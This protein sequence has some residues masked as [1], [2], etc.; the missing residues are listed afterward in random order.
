MSG[1]ANLLKIILLGFLAAVY[2]LSALSRRY[3]HV[4]W[5]RAFRLEVKVTEEQR[6][7]RRRRAERIAGIELILVG[8]CA[9]IAYLIVTLMTWGDPS[10]IGLTV[11]SL[12]GVVLI[13]LGVF[14]IVRNRSGDRP[15]D[16]RWTERPATTGAAVVVFDV[17]H[18]ILLIRENYGHRRWGL[19]GGASEH[20]ETFEE[21]A[22][23]EALEETGISVAVG[24]R[25]GT[26]VIAGN[27]PHEVMVYLGSIRSGTPGVPSSGEIADVGWFAL[28]AIPEPTTN[29]LPS[30][31]VDL[32]QQTFGERRTVENRYP[33]PV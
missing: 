6:A 33:D 20:G 18:R 9:P 15:R 19:P 26:Y 11:S 1:V 14:A 28:D 24:I 21:T 22:I 17:Q 30:V 23:R 32:R 13:A 2:G 4:A 25:V 7:K 29:V 8:L 5:L 12:V 3:P 16:E 31:V 27:P 10:A